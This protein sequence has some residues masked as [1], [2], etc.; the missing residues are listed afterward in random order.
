MVFLR[1]LWRVSYSSMKFPTVSGTQRK[2]IQVKCSTHTYS[3]QFIMFRLYFHFFASCQ[4]VIK[5]S[6][7]GTM[8]IT[9]HF[10]CGI[11][12]RSIN[13]L[14]RWSVATS[15]LSTRLCT[16]NL[17][18]IFL[19]MSFIFLSFHR[20]LPLVCWM[21]EKRLSSHQFRVFFLLRFLLF[22]MRTTHQIL[23][24]ARVPRI[25]RQVSPVYLFQ[26]IKWFLHCKWT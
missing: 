5:G 23:P 4:H 8:I 24:L 15:K 18:L 12:G 2:D 14:F 7:S 13:N 17:E 10:S 20:S 25:V 16:L 22:V 11:I 9:N 1:S 26:L 21:K 19:K 6:Y 3:F